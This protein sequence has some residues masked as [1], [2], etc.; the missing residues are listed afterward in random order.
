MKLDF[1]IF[2]WIFVLRHLETSPDV[3]RR[4][5]TSLS[6]ATCALMRPYTTTWAVTRLL[7]GTDRV[8]LP[9]VTVSGMPGQDLAV[10]KIL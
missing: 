6:N 8:F 5:P 2:V 10:P 3:P 7:D 1:L 4:P 9:N